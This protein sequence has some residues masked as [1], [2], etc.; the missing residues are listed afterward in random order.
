[1]MRYHQF[2]SPA[3]RRIFAFRFF[4]CLKRSAPYHKDTSWQIVCYLTCSSQDGY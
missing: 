3:Y 1:M 4:S 2:E